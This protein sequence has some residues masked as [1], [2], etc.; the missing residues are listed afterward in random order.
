MANSLPRIEKRAALEAWVKKHLGSI[1]HELRVLHISGELVDLTLP[2]HSLSNAER[3]LLELATIAHDVGRSVDDDEHPA[4]GADM[5]L[6]DAALPISPAER[7]ALAYL[8]RFHRGQ[9]PA[10]G[11][12]GILQGGD[13]QASLRQVLAF[14]RAADALDSRWLGSPQLVMSLHRRE[15][16]INCY[17]AKD[18][19]KI[20]R[21]FTRKK[22]FR[23]L[24][25]TLRCS[26]TLDLAST[27]ALTLVA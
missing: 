20:R 27:D 13:N 22:K 10:P 8:T 21:M 7:R 12:D 23:L 16:R 18:T 14:L 2:L 15:V 25:E 4:I 24:E 11:H 1:S 26:V 19:P 3:H 17:V 9:V 6:K 5:L